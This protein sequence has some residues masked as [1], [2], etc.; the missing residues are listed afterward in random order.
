MTA[1]QTA[2][3][4]ALRLLLVALAL[5]ATPPAFAQ[6]VHE[7]TLRGDK[8]SGRYRFDPATITVRPG[9]ILRFVVATGSPH[10][11]VFEAGGLAPQTRAALNSAMPRRFSDL[12]GPLLS[13]VGADYRIV[14]PNIPPGRYRFFCQSH[15]AYDMTGELV[16][17]R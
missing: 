17:R 5:G 2:A 4:R 12:S 1:Y 3:V 8:D 7:I 11:V 13:S 14:V 6:K 9:D 16:V 10:N 15:Q